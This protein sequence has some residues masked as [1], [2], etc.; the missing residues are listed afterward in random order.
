[1][2]LYLTDS[3]VQYKYMNHEV[4]VTLSQRDWDLHRRGFGD[5]SKHNERVKEAIK[6]NLPGIIS[7]G[8]IITTD[9]H[10]KKK[11][12]LS[13]R[14]VELPHIR[15]GDNKRGVGTGSGD[16]KVGDIVDIDSGDGAEKGKGAGNQPGS[17]YYEAEI[18]MEELQRLVFEDLGLPYLTPRKKKDEQTT[19]VFDDIRKKRSPS[20]LDVMRTAYANMQRRALET[21][22]AEL[23]EVIPEDFRVRTWRERIKEDQDALVVFMRDVSGSMGEFES[24]IARS[25][26]WWT[27]AFLGYKYPNVQK[28]FI[29]HEFEAH[30][31]TEEQFFKRGEGGG[32]RISSANQLALDV[33]NQR[34]SPDD[35]NIYVYHISDGVNWGQ[36]NQHCIEL[37][38]R[39]LKLPIN[40]Y[41]Y[42]QIGSEWQRNV[43]AVAPEILLW[44]EKN[45]GLMG[46]YRKKIQDPRFESAHI[47]N[48]EDVWPTMQQF[49]DPKKQ[50]PTT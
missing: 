24:Y 2:G 18:T 45:Q 9:P 4:V 28:L 37:V 33:I 43:F 30:E 40:Q 21:G 48:K 6:D 31:V 3:S 46:D 44:G 22:K 36:D 14:S 11:I 39:M 12:R 17:E 29:A 1:M 8:T 15:Y 7:D 47:K 42:L 26:S 13:L 16:E 35:Y 38:K 23:G 25:F 41:G 27:V 19:I 50:L 32:T 20:N 34:F 5:E 49:F 10:T